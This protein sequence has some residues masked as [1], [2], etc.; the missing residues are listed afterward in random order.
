MLVS[1]GVNVMTDAQSNNTDQ[2]ARLD[3][4]GPTQGVLNE[5][6]TIFTGR[7]IM[8]Y[9]GFRKTKKLIFS[10]CFFIKWDFDRRTNHPLKYII[11]HI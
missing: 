9:L 10:E 6:T 2:F 4:I 3:P 11:Y 1:V 5:R 7:L 8:S